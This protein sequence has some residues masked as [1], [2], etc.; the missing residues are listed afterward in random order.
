MGD[1]EP[2][3]RR[4]VH[5][6]ASDG[7][8]EARSS[9]TRPAIPNTNTW[10]ILSHVM[11]TI[12]H[13]TQFHGLEDEDAP[14]HLSAS[15][16]YVIPSISRMCLRTQ[17]IC[18]SSH[19]RS[20]GVHLL[21]LT[22]SQTTISPHG[23][24]FKPSSSRNTVHLPVPL[25][26]GTRSTPS[27]W[28][29]TSLITWPRRAAG[30]HIMDK[31]EPAECEEMIESFAI[32]EQQRPSTRTS[33]PSARSSTSSPR[34]VHQ[35]TPA[36][37]VA[38]AL[39]AMA[40]EIKELKLRDIAQSL[41]DRQGGPSSGPNASVMA[42]SIKIHREEDEV[43]EEISH[44][45]DYGIPS[46][47][48]V[49]K[50]NWR[51]RFAEID[52]KMIEEH[53]V[54]EPPV[55]EEESVDEEIVVEK[56]AEKEE[57]KKKGV[58]MKSPEI[59]LSRVPYPARL[60]PHKHAREYGH[61][62]HLQTSQDL[63]SN[64]KKLEGIS[65]VSLSEQCSTVVR[66]KLPE[67]LADSGRFTIPCLLGGFPLNH[68][69]ADLGAS[70]NLMPY[71]IYKQLDL[72]EPQPTRMSISLA[73]RSVKYPWG[74][75][76][77]LLV[78]VGKFVF[79]V[80]FVILDIEVDDKVPLI[81]GRLGE[82]VTFDA[83]KHVKDVGKHSH[84]VCMLYAFMDYHQDSDPCKIEVGEPAPDLGEPS[85]WAVELE[86]LLDEPD[87]YDKDVPDDL[88][89]M[90]TELE[91]I[92][93]KTPSAGMI[94]K[95]ES[96]KEPGDPNESLELSPSSRFPKSRLSRK[97]THALRD[98]C[99]LESVQTLS[100]GKF[101]GDSLLGYLNSVIFRP[102]KF[103]MWWKDLSA[104]CFLSS[105]FVRSNELLRL[106]RKK[107]V[108]VRIKEKPPD[109]LVCL[110]G[111]CPGRRVCKFLGPSPCH[112]LCFSVFV[113]CLCRVLQGFSLDSVRKI[114]GNEVP[115]I[116]HLFL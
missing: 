78:K 92:I 98:V 89:E 13:D 16:A 68:A 8:T 111:K 63:L 30:G 62:L 61:F 113:F 110:S 41:K 27:R 2:P 69:L 75:G 32:A 25:A 96:V 107:A 20:L 79:P 19:S 73:D 36:T 33:I 105:L 12:T 42:V 81:L 109:R 95:V 26:S 82:S 66:N 60:L 11:S 38:V 7:V 52:A 104:T 64:K 103:K 77:N 106:W 71:S 108:P 70:V 35:V 44:S 97:R 3:A 47:A 24:I 94:E 116:L 50:I 22:P 14:G 74:I 84:S 83:T 31:L 65:E 57:E 17:S 88:R 29:P 48:E 4:T 9:I 28:T 6:R 101:K 39:A 85:D 114:I 72:G 86:K 40:N 115:G 34:G 56:P 91:D 93:G 23:R 90:M 46:P 43:E 45:A 55:E 59:D 15:R 18:I 53:M 99:E 5:Q 87:E 37:S 49:K 102:G 21:G 80:D 10:Q 76:E 100:V 1:T 51:T 67:K 54:E 112:F 58:E